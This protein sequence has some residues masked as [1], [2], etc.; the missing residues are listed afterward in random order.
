VA[1][2]IMTRWG[3]QTG[4]DRSPLSLTLNDTESLEVSYDFMDDGTFPCATVSALIVSC[5]LFRHPWMIVRFPVPRRWF[6]LRY[7]VS[8]FAL[9]T[10]WAGVRRCLTVCP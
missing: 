5:L 2:D 4:S 7:V 6:L 1:P 9:E 3:L 8:Q 10:S